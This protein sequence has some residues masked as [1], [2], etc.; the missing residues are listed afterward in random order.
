MTEIVGWLGSSALALCAL[1][2]VIQCIKTKSAEGVNLAFLLL[3]LFGEIFTLL[4]VLIQH[5][6]DYPLLFN[7]GLNIIFISI[8]LYFARL[9]K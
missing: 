3:W 6:F 4:Y 5:G 8:I 1:P 9:N 7:Y 2:Q